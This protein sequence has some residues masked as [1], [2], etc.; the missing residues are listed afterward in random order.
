MAHQLL[1]QTE[2]GASGDMILSA[3]IDLLDA[4]DEFREVFENIGLDVKV[5]VADVEKNHLRCKQVTISAPGS[6]KATNWSEIEAFIA[7][8]PLSVAVKAN[9]ARI[10]QVIF[11]AEAAVHGESLKDVHLH[12]VGADDSLVDILGFCW[13][14]EKLGGCPIFFTTLVTGQGSV[15]TR[16]GIL[17]VPPPAVLRLVQG[18]VCRS[19]DIEGELLTPTG[20]AVLTTFG[21]QA[22]AGQGARMLKTGCGG[23]HRTFESTPN[24]LR[25]FLQ[26]RV[27]AAG[28]DGVWVLEANV[29][30]ASPELLAHAAE[31][32]VEAGALDVFIA[33]GLMK[34]GRPGFQLTVLCRPGEREGVIAA[35][36][37]ESTAIGLRQRYSERVTLDRE[38]RIVR[39]A[40]REVRL[41][42]SSWQGRQVN[43]KPEFADVRRLAGELGIPVKEAMQMAMGAMHEEHGPG[44]D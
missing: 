1:F 23:G 25:V 10:F 28:A 17:P 18:L 15:R 6:R 26:E 31:K 2:C 16:H 30:D 19:G 20:A 21:T 27:A 24:L 32:I 43:S 22:V 5:V 39:V 29:D 7:A 8:T 40:G 33:P 11:A 35:V 13:L 44:K 41:K 34:K 37:R 9:A 38:T 4:G 14:W 3:L 12:E 42:V 36:F